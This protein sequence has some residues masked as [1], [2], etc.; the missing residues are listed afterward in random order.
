MPELRPKQKHRRPVPRKHTKDPPFG[1]FHSDVFRHYA[2]FFEI[3]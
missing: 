3:F 1:V 2:T